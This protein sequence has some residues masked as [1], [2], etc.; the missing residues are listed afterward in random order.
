MRGIQYVTDDS[1]RRTAVL[2]SLEEWGDAWEDIQ[3]ILVLEARRDEPTVSLDEV[4]KQ[5]DG[6]TAAS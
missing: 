1:G 3:D 6:S 5:L 4:T 2:I